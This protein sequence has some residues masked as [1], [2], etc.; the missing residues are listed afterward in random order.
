MYRARTI[1]VAGNA[2]RLA[3]FVAAIYAAGRFFVD[4][5]RTQGMSPGAVFGLL[6]VTGAIGLTWRS[7]LDLRRSIRR[8]R[9]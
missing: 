7:A 4:A 8:L 9:G 1:R 3:L 2:L 5:V 6:L